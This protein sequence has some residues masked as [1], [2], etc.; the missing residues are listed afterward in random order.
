MSA[1][2]PQ[3]WDLLLPKYEN[4]RYIQG[5]GLGSSVFRKG[6]SALSRKWEQ[7]FQVSV[8]AFGNQ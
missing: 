2:T 7:P 8:S 6:R 1:H 5:H 4:A 3:D